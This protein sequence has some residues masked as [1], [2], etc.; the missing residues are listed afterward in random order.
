MTSQEDK[1]NTPDFE[2]AA[3][4][5]MSPAWNVLADVLAG[6][7]TIKAKTIE[8]LPK[9]AA[10][11]DDAYSRRLKRSLFFE[12]YRDCVVNLTGMVF[13]KSPTLGDD[14]PD[15]LK[16]LAENVDNAGTHFD[17]FLQRVFEDGFY[18]HSF[19]V[20][21]LPAKSADVRTAADELGNRS[22]WCMRQAKDAVNFRPLV[23][24]G[25][26]EIGQISFK[27]CNKEPDGRFGEKEVTRYRVYFLDEAGNAQW[28]LW[29]EMEKETSSGK[30]EVILEDSGPILTKKGKALKRLPIAVHYGEH[31]GFLESRPPLKGIADIN[32]DGGIN[33]SDASYL[34]GHKFLGGPPPPAPP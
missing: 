33:I 2:C 6:Q 28:E 21:D 27:E 3:Y 7:D 18:G 26:T 23:M 9:E 29:R 12:D 11:H 34:L 4:T 24:K 17:V 1:K 16:Q 20:V 19:I 31:E 25:K 14:V 13:R 5:A 30:K 10:E 8:Y 32:N 15:Y 22:Y